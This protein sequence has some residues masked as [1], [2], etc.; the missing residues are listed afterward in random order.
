M[1]GGHPL[2][3]KLYFGYYF[4]IPAITQVVAKAQRMLKFKPTDFLTGLQES[5]RWYV[6]NQK[7]SK[8]DYSFEDQL[9]AMPVAPPV[10]V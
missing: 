10:L 7:K 5:Y 4:D 6:R 2:G 8:I 1:A 9:M 3:P